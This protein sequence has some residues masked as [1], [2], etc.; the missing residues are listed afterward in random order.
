MKTAKLTAANISAGFDSA[1]GALR[2]FLNPLTGWNIINDPALGMSF[3]MVA[4]LPHRLNHR[5]FGKD[6]KL[7]RFEKDPSGKR[8]TFTWENPVGQTGLTL[9]MTFTGVVALTEFGLEFSGKI[10]NRSA[11]RVEA[12]AWP[13][14]GQITP[15]SANGELWRWTAFLTELGLQQLM[16]LFRNDQGYWGAD[17][18]LQKAHSPHSSFVLL[19][20]KQQGLYVGHHDAANRELVQ[21]LFELKPGHRESLTGAAPHSDLQTGQ[22]PRV[23]MSINHFPFCAPGESKLLTP[24]VLRPYSGD[25]HDGIESYKRWRATWH[26]S[27]PAPDW[28]N[29]VHSWQQVQINSIAGEQRCRYE[30]LIEHGRQC[31]N[32]GV[33]AIQLTG[34]TSGGQDGRMP[35]HDIDP[36]LGTRQD[37]KKAVADLRALGIRTILYEKFVYAD[38]STDWYKRELYKYMAQDIHGNPEGHSGWAYFLP[39]HFANFNMRRLNWACMHHAQW[40]KIC[41]EEYEKSLEFDADGVILD[42][43][44]HPREDGRY[45][46]ASDHG[47]PVPAFNPQGDSRLMEELNAIAARQKRPQV[48]LGESVHDLQT[49]EYGMTYGR[50][51][52]GYIPL[53]RYLD[54][55]YPIMMAVTGYDDRE[56]LNACLMFRFVISYEPLNFKGYLDEF[57]LT[58]EYGKKIDALRR[59]YRAQ[60]WDAVFHDTRGA[61]VTVDGKPHPDYAVFWEVK[62]SRKAVVLVNHRSA[63]SVMAKVEIEGYAGTLQIITPENPEPAK[64]TSNQIAVPPRSAVV[65]MQAG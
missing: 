13:C 20:D 41:C 63:D 48:I 17:Y 36:R 31:A 30:R 54:P 5:V 26:K 56:K 29:E 11:Q 38:V 2:E 22:T 58:I 35:S 65:V 1:S 43:S 61:Q 53:L 51:N 15:P 55:F 34:W 16:P 25:W 14:L 47:H 28:C 33:A 7:T 4:P 10:I 24:I 8:L 44:C 42:E 32:H 37:L 40:R 46:F 6:Q 50:F 62:S 21:F 52:A 12:I 39:S 57:P 18:P 60:L 45:C 19:G 27:A 3:E 49:T 64:T 9:D 59:R 23:Q